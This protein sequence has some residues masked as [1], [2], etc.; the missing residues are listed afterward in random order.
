ML[1]QDLAGAP[2]SAFY[3]HMLVDDSQLH[4]GWGYLDLDRDMDVLL[5]R[6]DPR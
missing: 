3:S 2:G 4:L 5:I 6:Y 1:L